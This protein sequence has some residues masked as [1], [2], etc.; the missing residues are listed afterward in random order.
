MKEK[1]QRRPLDVALLQMAS[2]DDWSAN[3]AK[4]Q[5]LASEAKGADLLVLPEM[6]SFLVPDQRGDERK[7][8]AQERAAEVRR[9]LAELAAGRGVSVLGG[10]SFEWD[11]SSEKVKNRSLLFDAKGV[12]VAQY[13]KIHLF[14]NDV[15]PGMFRESRTVSAGSE[16]V[17]TRVKDWSVGMSICY[18]LR[19]P[20]LFSRYSDLEVDAVVLPAAFTK[21]TGEAH[22]EVLLRSRAIENQCFVWACNQAMNSPS[23]VQCWGHSSIIDPW[24]KVLAK[25]SGD[26]QVLR[27]S[28][29]PRSLRKVRSMLPVLQHKRSFDLRSDVAQESSS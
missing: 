13:D 11:E 27:A 26:E 19:F 15:I 23:G 6:W 18:D 5:Q 22:W 8:F 25:A 20:A 9:F 14:D 16:A 10:S 28:C 2:G 29:D 1:E 3:Q 17:Q 24:G 21:K 4:V 7:A 12:C